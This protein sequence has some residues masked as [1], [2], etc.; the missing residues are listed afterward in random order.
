MLNFKN[1]EEVLTHP[2]IKLEEQSSK[3]IFLNKE[4]K[5]IRKIR[6]DGCLITSGI[7]C[8]Y[9]VIPE[10]GV[11][12][13]VELK[14]TDVKHAINQIKTTIQT[15][16]KGQNNQKKECFIITTSCPLTST[17]I[18]KFKKEFNTK[19]NS[20]LIVKNSPYEHPI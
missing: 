15:I 20:S 1:C 18:L 19:L 13:Y 5:M 7:R 8:D 16:H 14:G 2:K 17:E 12:H 3:L 9:L 6:I 4:N 11:E 10:S